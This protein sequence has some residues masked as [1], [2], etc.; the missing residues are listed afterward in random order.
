MNRIGALAAALLAA[1]LALL[2]GSSPSAVAGGLSPAITPHAYTS[3]AASPSVVDGAFER[4][5][6]AI[7]YDYTAPQL[8]VDAASDGYLAR[9][10]TVTGHYPTTY[11]PSVQLLR[12]DSSGAANLAAAGG[13]VGQARPTSGA[14][15]AANA[16]EDVGSGV[17]RSPSFIVKPNGE[18]VIVPKGA[19]GPFPVESGRGFMFRG[20]SGG[21]GLNDSASDVRIMDPVTGGK[22]PKPNGYASYL[23]GGGQT[24]NPFT[25]QTVG[26]SSLWWHWEFLP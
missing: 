19:E 13:A 25:G 21:H 18:T 14:I 26:K 9:P 17:A 22:Y 23:N 20:G 5:P 12:I 11:D 10:S 4:G 1:V 8:A 3:P 24:I 2:V 15:V 6:P 7:T 16:A